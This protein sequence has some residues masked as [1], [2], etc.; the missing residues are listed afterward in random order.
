MICKNPG[1][2]VSPPACELIFLATR[3][4]AEPIGITGTELVFRSDIHQR[5]LNDGPHYQEFTQKIASLQSGTGGRSAPERLREV[6]KLADEA[7]EQIGNVTKMP[8]TNVPASSAVL[9]KYG[10]QDATQGMLFAGVTLAKSLASLPGWREK[11]ELC[12]RILSTSGFEPVIAMTD[13]I[14]SELFRIRPA[15]DLL[16]AGETDVAVASRICLAIAGDTEA[17]GYLT[18]ASL[19]LQWVAAIQARKMPRIFAAC[20]GRLKEMLESPRPLARN[21]TPREWSL[22]VN[23]RRRIGA[24]PDLDSHKDLRGLL[25]RRANSLI[26]SPKLMELL[27]QEYMHSRRIMLV[28][29]LLNE[30]SEPQAKAKLLTVINDLF[31]TLD[32]RRD[33][34][35]SD[36]KEIA[37]AF[38]SIIAAI[39]ASQD[40]APSR[41]NAFVAA[42]KA[43]AN[44]ASPQTAANKRQ[45]DRTAGGPDDFIVIDG[46]KIKLKNW[47]PQ[48]LL[49][50]PFNGYAALG[51]KLTITV[52][53]RQPF[54]T[55]NYEVDA[56]VVRIIDG[57]IAVRYK[58]KDRAAEQKVRA[59]FS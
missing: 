17:Q 21:D 7:M 36:T 3:A 45:N 4:Y 43:K 15:A 33:M 58:F 56:E 31:E 28:L 57:I 44:P 54:L 41:K 10:Q 16:F 34:T 1:D 59:F 50:G 29:R 23:L 24:L 30:V 14:L 5:I 13:Q 48:G 37:A 39:S 35:G 25:S 55:A 2:V 9:D 19:A 47:S 27:A 12:L 52:L 26:A 20:H 40:I 22:I 51:D 8:L 18:K 11:I 53:I 49:F 42:L 46:Q 6:M 38:E 32:V